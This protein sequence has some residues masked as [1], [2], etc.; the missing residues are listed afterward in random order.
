MLRLSSPLIICL[1]LCYSCSSESSKKSNSNELALKLKGTSTPIS[2]TLHELP[3]EEKIYSLAKGQ[4][5]KF[6]K[7]SSYRKN[8]TLLRI[9]NQQAFEAYSNKF[10]ELKRN[11]K[12]GLD[13]FPSSINPV[14]SKWQTFYD[15]LIIT[16]E[17][18]VFPKLNYKEELVFVQD[19]NIKSAYTDVVKLYL[20]M[21]S[22][23]V[24]V[25][26]DGFITTW[27]VNPNQHVTKNQEIA[28]YYPSH[29]KIRYSIPKEATPKMID[30]AKQEMIRTNPHLQSIREFEKYLEVTV[31]VKSMADLQH[32]PLSFSAGSTSYQ[33]IIPSNKVKHGI[34]SYSLNPDLKALKNVKVEKTNSHFTL[35]LKDSIIYLP[36]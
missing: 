23:F 18:P 5:E 22:Y 9:K 35:N 16:N 36:Q 10:D 19:F 34:L 14:Q 31:S 8:S 25:P 2:F 11:L 12:A 15:Q 26:F 20:N 17:L 32:I 1:F 13:D 30:S 4:I 3:R 29:F 6:N 28:S 33:F 27:K 21:E 24:T 7:K